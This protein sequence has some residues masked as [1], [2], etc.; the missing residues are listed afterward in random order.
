M[1]QPPINF[2]PASYRE[3]L[4]QRRRNRRQIIWAL[5]LLLALGGWWLVQQRQTAQTEAQAQALEVQVEHAR[6]QMAEV[7][8]LREQYQMLRHQAH[9]QRSLSEP[10]RRTQIMA[11]LG[12]RMPESVTLTRMHMDTQRPPA[13]SLVQP[14]ARSTSSIAHP[15]KVRMELTAL[16]PDDITVANLLTALKEHPLFGDVTIHH[17]HS[18]ERYDVIAR[19]FRMS[20][21]VD[22]DRRF[23]SDAQEPATEDSYQNRTADESEEHSGREGVAHVD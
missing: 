15:H 9:V 4:Q 19:E 6:Q 8:Q 2:L 20:A 23:E 21:V 14:G 18:V 1:P 11:T 22:L 16:A 10:L 5:M 7:L 3:R 17:S 13:G 12:A